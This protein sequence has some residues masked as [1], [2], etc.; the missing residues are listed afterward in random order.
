MNDTKQKPIGEVTHF[1]GGIGVAVV[2]CSA[3]VAVGDKVEF[4][5]ATTDFSETISSMQLD[6]QPVE[7]AKKGQ[8]IAIKVGKKVREGDTVFSA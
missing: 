3:S 1:F 5:G 2:K 4:K 7:K 6:H 8:E